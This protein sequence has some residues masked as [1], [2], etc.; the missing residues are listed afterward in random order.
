MGNRVSALTPRQ[1]ELIDLAA[2]GLTD[3]EISLRLSVGTGTIRTY[4][5]RL[6]HK[7]DAQSRSEVVAKVLRD[8]YESAAR[9]LACT[10]MLFQECFE[11]CGVGMAVLDADGVF[12]IANEAFCRVFGFAPHEVQGCCVFEILPSPLEEAAR[13][14]YE[15]LRRGPSGA[16]RSWLVPTKNGS[17]VQVCARMHLLGNGGHNTLLVIEQHSRLAS[18]IAQELAS[19]ETT[20]V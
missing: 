12:E 7:L 1:I 10:Q 11:H 8:R 18:G 6:R 15:R 14:A 16:S 20:T 9:E 3:K 19:I 13:S 4:W 17:A 5:E 2:Q